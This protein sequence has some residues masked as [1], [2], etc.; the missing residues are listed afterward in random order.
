MHET[1][2]AHHECSV[3]CKKTLGII[4]SIVALRSVALLCVAF[5]SVLDRKECEQNGCWRGLLIRTAQ[6]DTVK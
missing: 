1:T 4:G 2:D 5:L 3:Q 6:Y